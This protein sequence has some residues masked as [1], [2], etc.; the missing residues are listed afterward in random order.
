MEKDEPAKN[1]AGLR[2]HS[3]ILSA[4]QISEVLNMQPDGFN[5]KGVKVV[6]NHPK[7]FVHPS[8]MWRLESDCDETEPLDRHI[9]RLVDFIESRESAFKRLTADCEFD[10]FCGYFPYGWTGHVDLSPDLLKRL[11]A[12]PIKIVIKLYEPMSEDDTEI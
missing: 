10:I 3:D 7:S 9:S 1:Q 12:I 2:I 5:V 4:E 11:T 6:P 8:H